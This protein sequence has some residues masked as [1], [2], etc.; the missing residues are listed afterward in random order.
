[1]KGEFIAESSPT[2]EFQTK[3][4]MTPGCPS[5]LSRPSVGVDSVHELEDELGALDDDDEQQQEGTDYAG[6]DGDYWRT[7]TLYRIWKRGGIPIRLI[8]DIRISFLQV[9]VAESG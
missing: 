1:M 5:P 2:C 7:R 6:R 3:T 8:N 9:T 4:F